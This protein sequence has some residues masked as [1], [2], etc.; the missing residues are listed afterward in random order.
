[1]LRQTPRAFVERLDFRSSAG[2]RV[3]VVV[4]DLGVLEPDPE[5]REL[6][7]TRV[8]PGVEPDDVRAA[9]GWEL[10]VAAE[11]R[12]TDAPSERELA[13]VRAL[14]S[15]DSPSDLSA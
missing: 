15:E 2:D 1:M 13:A 6:T 8:H 7:L 14:T 4:T 12:P 5:T 9:T 3:S 11:L 10:R